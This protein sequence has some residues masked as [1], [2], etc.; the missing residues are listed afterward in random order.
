MDGTP[1]RDLEEAIPLLIIEWPDQ[2]DF[3]LQ[4]IEKSVLFG[5]PLSR[6]GSRSG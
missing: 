6:P 2:G 5:R 4:H 3:A 1:L